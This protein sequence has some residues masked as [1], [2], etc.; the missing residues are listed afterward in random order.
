MAS[1]LIAVRGSSCEGEEELYGP[2]PILLRLLCEL[3]KGQLCIPFSVQWEPA[4]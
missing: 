1:L 4:L 2:F 3:A